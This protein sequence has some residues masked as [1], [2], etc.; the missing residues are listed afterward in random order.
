GKARGAMGTDGAYYKP[1]RFGVV[2]A[3]YADEPS[4]FLCLETRNRKRM[5]FG[6]AAVAEGI[7]GPSRLPL[8]F[9]CFFFDYDLDGRLD[10]LTCNGHLEPDIARSR[11]DQTYAQPAQLL[12]KRGT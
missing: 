12:L 7:S 5:L 8:K 10:L 9:G 4:T 1:G 6:D 2:L 3:N 11:P